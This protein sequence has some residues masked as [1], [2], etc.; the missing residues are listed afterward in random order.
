MSVPIPPR[1]ASPFCGHKLRDRY[2][3]QL[4]IEQAKWWNEPF[5]DASRRGKKML[6]YSRDKNEGTYRSGEGGGGPAMQ[7]RIWVTTGRERWRRARVVRYNKWDEN[8]NKKE[9]RWTREQKRPQASTPGC[10]WFATENKRKGKKKR[11]MRRKEEKTK[12]KH[13]VT[14]KRETWRHQK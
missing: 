8:L 10:F 13:Y 12:G 5:F 3:L 7:P 4:R 9:S 2:K 1:E 6:K 11:I 14:P